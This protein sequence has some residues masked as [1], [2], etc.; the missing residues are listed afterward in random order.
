M[1]P[2][3]PFDGEPHAPSMG[4][5]PLEPGQWLEPDAALATELAEKRAILAAFPRL[6]LAAVAEP[7]AAVAGAAAAAELLELVGR[8]V[9][10]YHPEH[11]TED[12]GGVRVR[13][14]GAVVATRVEKATDDAR[15]AL[16]HL[17]GLLQEDVC[18]LAPGDPAH[19]V[20]GVVCFPSRWNL[21]E[22]IGLDAAAIHGP[23]PGFAAT[24]ARPAGNFLARLAPGRA[25]ARLNWTIHD[26]DTRFAPHPVPARHGLTAADVLTSTYLRVERQTLRRLPVSGFVVFTI[27]TYLDRLDA[28]A[29]D[30]GRRER[31][32]RTLASLPG[33]AVA[34]KGMTAFLEPLLEALARPA[35]TP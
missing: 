35:P 22:K 14:T 33:E 26:S 5:Q 16:R 8:H 17:A 28:V 4:L 27:R 34:Y 11:Y 2:H 20:A 25:F 7:P 9:V 32:R 1:S 15:P 31:L 29:A 23:V 10:V 6:V 13:A 19:L 3:F 12:P 30:S 24:L 18:L 21:A